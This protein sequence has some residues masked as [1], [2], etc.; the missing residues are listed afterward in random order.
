MVAFASP[1]LL[2]LSKPL[3][4]CLGRKAGPVKV[5]ASAALRQDFEI[6][7]LPSLPGYD[8]DYTVCG[9]EAV[10]GPSA[11]AMSIV[12][13]RSCPCRIWRCAEASSIIMLH[14][15]FFGSITQNLVVLAESRCRYRKHVHHRTEGL[16]AAMPPTDG[17]DL[18]FRDF[19]VF[20]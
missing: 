10:L 17:P 16:Q 11:I 8:N 9:G 12:S 14:R 1:T 20:E 19:A 7:D 3:L 13:A 18:A 15:N 6:K 4:E 5:T 2:M